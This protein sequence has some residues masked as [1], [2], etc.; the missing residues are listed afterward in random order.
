MTQG[1][2]PETSEIKIP[3]PDELI[4]QDIDIK[5]VDNE[6]KLTASWVTGLT[7]NDSNNTA[8]DSA[9]LFDSLLYINILL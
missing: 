3:I 7:V 2:A 5:A 4:G 1:G 8:S 6:T 9:A